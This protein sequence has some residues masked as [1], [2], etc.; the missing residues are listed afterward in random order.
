[1]LMIWFYF[2]LLRHLGILLPSSQSSSPGLPAPS[3]F[4]VFM[5]NVY[6]QCS[7]SAHTAALFYRVNRIP[8]HF[9]L[10]HAAQSYSQTAVRDTASLGPGG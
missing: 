9:L 10:E 5:Y 8:P 1:M 7:G 4:S 2:T 3:S 6:L